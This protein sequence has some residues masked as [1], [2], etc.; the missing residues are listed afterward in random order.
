MELSKQT[1]NQPLA[2]YIIRKVMQFF[3][4]IK[5]YV[6]ALVCHRQQVWPNQTGPSCIVCQ[7]KWRRWMTR[8]STH[9]APSFS[10]RQRIESGPSWSVT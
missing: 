9:P 3:K 2:Q 7:G 4:T 6:L 5:Q 10:L 1:L 8:Y